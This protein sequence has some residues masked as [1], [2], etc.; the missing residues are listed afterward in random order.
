MRLLK[1]RFK[2]PACKMTELRNV[3][4]LWL[5]HMHG[6]KTAHRFMTD[7]DV[8][9]EPVALAAGQYPD[10]LRIE[11]TKPRFNEKTT[12]AFDNFVSQKICAGQYDQ[13]TETDWNTFTETMARVGVSVLKGATAA[14]CA[15]SAR[16]SQTRGCG[17]TAVWQRRRGSRAS[18]LR[19]TCVVLFPLGAHARVRVRAYRG[20]RTHPSRGRA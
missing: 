8:L 16:T 18:S 19:T 15:V 7:D 20:R 5:Q 6:D 9:Y 11:V 1:T 14:A 2:Q 3:K 13:S 4:T 12:I 10:Q 17:R